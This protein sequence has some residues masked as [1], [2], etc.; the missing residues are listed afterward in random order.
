MLFGLLNAISNN[1]MSKDWM[2]GNSRK[3]WVISCGCLLLG[4][5][6]MAAAVYYNSGMIRYLQ[7]G[8][9][10]ERQGHEKTR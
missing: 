9:S 1:G 10:I 7:Q 5:A 8:D 4:I 2:N 6:L 3:R